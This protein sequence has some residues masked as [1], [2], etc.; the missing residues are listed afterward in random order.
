MVSVVYILTF[1]HLF[2][3]LAYKMRDFLEWLNQ[4][5]VRMSA[6]GW[7]FTLVGILIISSFFLLIKVIDELDNS[8]IWTCCSWKDDDL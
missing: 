7:I 8:D 4:R 5:S 1:I 2:W 6:F 3:C